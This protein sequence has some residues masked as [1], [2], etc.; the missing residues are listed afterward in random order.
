MPDYILK[1]LV[2][3][4]SIDDA[5]A[6][7]EMHSILSG[8]GLNPPCEYTLRRLGEKGG[9]VVSKGKLPPDVGKVDTEVTNE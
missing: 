8:W 3:F 2:P 6:R 4:P 1:I 5:E 7:E 9:K